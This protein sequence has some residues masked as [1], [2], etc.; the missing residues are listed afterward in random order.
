MAPNSGLM[1][2][3]LTR[4]TALLLFIMTTA[5]VVMRRNGEWAGAGKGGH[6]GIERDMRPNIRAAPGDCH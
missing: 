3:F 2:L 4:P 5:F 1:P 6:G